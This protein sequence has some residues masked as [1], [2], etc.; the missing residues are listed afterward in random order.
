VVA[1]P[2]GAEKILYKCQELINASNQTI[3]LWNLTTKDELVSLAGHTD[4]ITKIEFFSTD[5]LVSSAE[6]DT[7][8]IWAIPQVAR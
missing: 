1:H 3:R 4:E 7:I 6:D 2:V 5:R 8:R